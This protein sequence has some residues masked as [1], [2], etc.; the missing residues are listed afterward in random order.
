MN[1]MHKILYLSIGNWHAK[2]CCEHHDVKS[3]PYRRSEIVID[4]SRRSCFLSVFILLLL[5]LFRFKWEMRVC[6]CTCACAI[7][8][9]LLPPIRPSILQ[10]FNFQ[11]PQ[12][13]SSSFGSARERTPMIKYRCSLLEWIAGAL[14]R[15]LL[16]VY[17]NVVIT[18]LRQ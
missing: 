18:K 12:L 11:S 10:N 5:L 4:W 14:V 15:L 17:Y 2:I 1:S 8:C 7:C 3:Y 16:A 9:F 13:L 6:F